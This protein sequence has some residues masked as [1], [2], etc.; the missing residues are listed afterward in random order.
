MSDWETKMQAI[1]NESIKENVTSLAGVPSWMLV[2]LN[3]VLE[4]TGHT[5]LLELWPNLEV[6]FHGGVS[7]KPYE[8][9]YKKI[10]P[11]SSFKYYETYNAS[12]GFFAIQD[13]NNSDELLLMLDYGIFYEFIPMD[14]YGTSRVDFN[15]YT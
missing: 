7:F 9:Q 8:K 10:I 2:L 11:S 4:T 13:Q 14:T 1:V 5:N 6:Y 12:E 3:N 15:F